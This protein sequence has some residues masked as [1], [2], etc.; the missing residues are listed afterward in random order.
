M[1]EYWKV[2]KEMF[3]L[4]C[5][6]KHV[7]DTSGT[8]AL[9]PACIYEAMHSMFLLHLHQVDQNTEQSYVKLLIKHRKVIMFYGLQIIAIHPSS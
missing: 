7:L 8:Q 5:F 1:I 4:E 6:C 2:Q 9:N 3:G